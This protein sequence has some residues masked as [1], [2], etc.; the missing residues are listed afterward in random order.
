MQW[1]CVNTEYSIHWVLH[2]P[3]TA[4]SQDPLSPAPSQ[5]LISSRT[6]LYSTLFIPT[7]T[8]WPM[9]TV[10]AAVPPPYQSTACRSTTSKYSFNLDWS[11]PPSAS[12]NL[13]H[14]GLQVHL[15]VQLGLS[16]QVHLSVTPSRP[17]NASPNP[18]DHCLQVH[19]W[20]TRSRP[21]N[22]SPN[23]LDYGLQVHL[24]VQLDLGLQVHLSITRSRP[25][26]ASRNPLDHGLQMHLWVTRS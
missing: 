18:L 17:P 5:S 15:W 19:L 16:L 26:N 7:I 13:L 24:W 9:K 25:P 2:T 23:S 22:A 20:A 3:C 21:P 10:S 8:S 12:P 4:S 14:H 11:S 6:L 1:S